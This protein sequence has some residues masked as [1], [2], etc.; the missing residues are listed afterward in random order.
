MID[1]L[2]APTP[3]NAYLFLTLTMLFWAGNTIVGRWASEH[4]PPVTL[5]FLRWTGA[6]VLILPLAW[7]HLKREWPAIRSHMPILLLLG[8]TGA[9]L[10]N[11]LHYI[12][13]TGT[14]A[15]NVGI[16]NSSAPIMIVIMS[17]FLNR[18]PFHLNQVIGITISLAG[19]LCVMSRGELATLTSLSF[20]VGD[21]VMLIA[22]AVW[23]VYTAVLKRRP[24]L[25]MW[26]FAA[27]TY[28]VASALNA[29]LASYELASGAV[30]RWST[31]SVLAIAYTAV[32]PSFLAYLMFNRGVEILGP[33]RASPFMHLVAFFTIVL[34]ILF[35]GEV[36]ALYHGIGL[37]L[38]LSGIWLAVQSG[39][40]QRAK[41]TE[42]RNQEPT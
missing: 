6:A 22:T 28:L 10:Y 27:V 41:V 31:P 23:A 3:A 7:P 26:S 42:T 33:S 40:D 5:A 32:F 34:A 8:I 4:V 38:I 15:T 24:I 13:L 25:S 37:A 39:D 1:R 19:V 14:T 30:I 2:K 36:P 18:E 17:W 20:N 16:I 9:G 29:I 12:A 11:T 35:L 21:L